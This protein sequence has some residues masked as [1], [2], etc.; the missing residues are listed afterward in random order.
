MILDLYGCETWS[1]SIKKKNIVSY[2]LC[3]SR[4]QKTLFDYKMKRVTGD[5]RKLRRIRQSGASYVLMFT[6]FQ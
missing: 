5:W 6:K 4:V 1:L 2:N 3:K